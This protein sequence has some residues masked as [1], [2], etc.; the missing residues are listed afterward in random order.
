MKKNQT[1]ISTSNIIKIESILHGYEEYFFHRESKKKM[2]IIQLK[3]FKVKE[4]STLC[5]DYTRH[6]IDYIKLKCLIHQNWLFFCS[7]RISSN[8]KEITTCI[9]RIMLKKFIS[10]PNILMTYYLFEITYNRLFN[11]RYNSNNNLKYLNL[12]KGI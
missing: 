9:L 11:S 4:K 3:G 8:E 2:S 12:I 7:S 10:L 1:P 6:S 5:I